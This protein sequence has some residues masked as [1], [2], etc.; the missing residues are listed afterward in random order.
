MYYIYIYLDPLRPGIYIY[1]NFIFNHEP[2]YVGRGKDNRY[3]VHTQK[4]SLKSKNNKNTRI[5][6][7][8]ENGLKPIVC[9]SSTGLTFDDSLLLERNTISKIGRKKLNT[10]P[11]T[12]LTSGG[13]GIPEMK[14]S[15]ESINKMRKTCLERG[16][17]KKFS[18]NMKGDKNSMSGKKWYRS[19][20]GIENFKNKM[21]GVSPLIG[22]TFLEKEVI[23]EKTSKTLKGRE[24]NESEK[25][26]RKI[27]MKKVWDERRKN[28]ITIEKKDIK[29]VKITNL[30]TNEE[31]IFN[32]LR[33]AAKYLNIH[34]TTIG[35]KYKKGKNINNMKIEVIT[36]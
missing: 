30:S 35:R 9:F 19:E 17:Y 32:T 28:N 2:F 7:I 5:K 6:N 1:E 23:F 20:K 4:Y 27:G 12:N 14:L 8:L 34:P 25:E 31:M 10:G 18:E 29:C 24:M 22:K 33:K 16:I 13:Q 3:M 11:L 36:K 15:E 21:T 26:K